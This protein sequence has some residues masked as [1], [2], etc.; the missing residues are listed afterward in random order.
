MKE[1]R[2]DV[3]SREKMKDLKGLLRNRAKALH[4]RIKITA[5]TGT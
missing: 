4:T 3:S 5:H 1:V 2:R